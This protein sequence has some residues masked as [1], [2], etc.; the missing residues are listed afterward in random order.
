MI[1]E[2]HLSPPGRGRGLSCDANGA[3]V[4]NIPL[5]KR[6]LVAGRERWE[7]RDSGELSKAIGA[8][9]G[10]PIDMS[11]KMGG[12]R[13]ISNALNEGDVAR[14]QI[15][16]VLLGIPDLPDLPVLSKGACSPADLRKFV[17]ELKWSG[18]LK[19]DWDPDE[20][21]RWPA[22]APDSQGGQF[23]PKGDD[24]TIG[25]TDAAAPR[26][27]HDT[28]PDVATSP[29]Q[30]FYGADVPSN[31]QPALRDDNEGIET[32]LDSSTRPS[33]N[34]A[35]DLGIYA[36][37]GSHIGDVQVASTGTIA[38][39][40]LIGDANPVDWA[41]LTRLA[42]GALRLG[43]G[44]IIMAASLLTAMDAARERAAV[45]A[46]FAK[47]GLDPT[48]A[49]DILAIRA[50]VW[51]QNFAPWNY[52]GPTVQFGVPS[53]GPQLESVSQFIMA[54]EL[55]RPGTLY[56]A[57]HGDARSN[58][59]LDVAVE[60]G[61]QGGAIFESRRPE[62]LP[63]SLQT[64]TQAARAALNLKT[65]D[66]MR[67]HHLIPVNVWATYLPITMLAKKAGWQQDGANNLIALPANEATQRKLAAGG[68]NL[69]IH[70]TNHPEYDGTSTGVIAV[71]VAGAV[72]D[73]TLTLTPAQA[74]AVY[75]KAERR[76]RGL[77]MDGMW[78]PRLR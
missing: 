58:K 25:Q 78:M 36:G 63:T 61:M 28:Q 56:L 59:Y 22:G 77:I 60:L 72:S 53:S 43:S 44:Q 21:P 30:R 50:Y 73:S 39:D 27:S 7:P 1:H 34:D 4:G 20:H 35:E 47:F 55:A 41:N 32:Q 64:S 70:S 40:G 15:A 12:V 71:E 13:A 33:A 19:A 52:F 23:A 10:V 8:S 18:L 65:N 17:D 29:R 76:M 14:A 37:Y 3:F 31:I 66:Q 75:E 54:L 48:N 46:A 51:A 26:A 74:R 67:A 2:F 38:L 11:L 68:L 49:A 9:F 6:S 16:T 42:N 45:D 24:A 69:P 62:N 5:L 57:Q